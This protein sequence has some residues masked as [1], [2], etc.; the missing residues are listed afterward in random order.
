MSETRPPPS[1]LNVG[2]RAKIRNRG[3]PTDFAQGKQ[4]ANRP[5]SAREDD[6]FFCPSMDLAAV[7]AAELAALDFCGGPQAFLDRLTARRQFRR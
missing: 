7:R 1:V 5:E 6:V 2:F 3:R 4:C